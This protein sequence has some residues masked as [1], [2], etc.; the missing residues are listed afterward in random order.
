[1]SDMW[2]WKEELAKAH[3]KQEEAGEFVHISKNQMSGLVKR[4]VQG[5]GLAASELDK[6]RWK[7]ILEYIEFKQEQLAEK[8]E[9]N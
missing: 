1:M 9:C 6:K 4:M 2:K 7:A 3:L 8:E 5:R